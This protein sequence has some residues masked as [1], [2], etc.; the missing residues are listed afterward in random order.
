MIGAKL[1][2]PDRLCVA[3]FGD[4]AF[5]QQGLDI[6]TS[7]REKLPILMVV[8]NNGGFGGY[9]KH[10]PSTSKVSPS[11]VSPSNVQNY[12]KVAEG[13]GAHSERIEKPDDLVPAFKRGIKSANAGRTAL[14]E[15][16]TTVFP[17]YPGFAYTP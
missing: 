5:G 7:V 4:A 17:R 1:A 2:C 16:I 8:M 11:K 9:E 10:H 15:C 12:S 14:I 6:E 3:F 13:L